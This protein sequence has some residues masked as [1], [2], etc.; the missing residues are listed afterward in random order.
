MEHKVTLIVMVK[1][2]GSLTSS[3]TMEKPYW[4]KTPGAEVARQAILDLRDMGLCEGKIYK[5]VKSD[6]DNFFVGVY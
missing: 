5:V 3:V 4:F 1:V 2:R 6:L